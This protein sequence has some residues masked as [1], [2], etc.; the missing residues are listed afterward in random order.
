M[1]LMVGV[2]LP[3]TN[4]DEKMNRSSKLHYQDLYKRFDARD[5][6]DKWTQNDH[7]NTNTNEHSHIHTQTN[8][9]L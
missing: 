6:T 8:I 9:F 4:S 2:N 1:F 7:T 3:L 5:P